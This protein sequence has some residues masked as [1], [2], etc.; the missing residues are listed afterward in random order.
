MSP[1][2]R[3]A[4]WDAAY[5]LGALSAPERLEYEGHLATCPTCRRAVAE[6]AGLPGLLA[7]VPPGE[8]LAMDLG[9]DEHV[10]Q[11]R[12]LMPALPTEGGVRA[13]GRGSRRWSRY[14]VPAAAAAALL[15][16]GVGGYALNA[17]IGDEPAQV[18]SS[19]TRMA[20]SP[21][22]PSPIT[23]VLDVVPSAKG[24][25][26]RVECQYGLAT[27]DATPSGA[28]AEYAIYIVD[29]SGKA[30]LAKTWK[31]NPD[32]VMRPKATSPLPLSQ[33]AAVEIRA[34][35]SGATL[36]RAQVH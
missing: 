31:A 19:Q 21:V 20:F 17:A 27:Q 29:R 35:D 11:P 9:E 8:V 32:R 1:E 7:Q 28:W 5:V 22:V 34:V 33:I 3:Y 24:T 15:M 13:A 25:E 6:L 4:D 16:G 10:P 23:A 2:D 36:M 26:F 12:S 18:D 14:A 30:E